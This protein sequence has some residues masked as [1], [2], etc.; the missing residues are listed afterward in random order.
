MIT[1]TD[2]LKATKGSC[3]GANPDTKIGELNFTGVS[4]DT[5]T[6]R[7]G[8]LFIALQGD[9]FDGHAYV[10]QAAAKGAAAAVVSRPVETPSG[11][12]Q[13]LVPDTLKA[14]Q[15]IASFYRM[16]FPHLKVVAIT[17]SNGKTSTKDMIAAVLATRY[18]VSKTRG[19]FNNEIGLP[20]TLLEIT[21]TTEIAVTEMGMRGL[22]QIKAMCAFAKPDVAVI[23]N[24]GSTHVGEL[25]SLA[26]IAK[27]KS[28]ILEDLP[29]DGFAVLNGDLPRVRAM[30]S[31]LHVPVSWFGL[32]PEDDVRAEAVEITATGSTFLCKAGTEEATIFLPLIGEHNVMNALAA[33]AVGRYFGVKLNDM[34]NALAAVR[35][36]DSRQEVLHFGSYTVIDDAYNA[37]PA[38]MEAAFAML[39]KL[40]QGAAAPCRTIAVVADMLELGHTS[41][42]AHASVGQMAAAAAT[43][44]LL[45]YGPETA[46]TVAAAKAAG[47]DARYFANKE[48]AAAALRTLLQPGDIVLL[49]GS[50]SMQVGV[51][52]ALVFKT[53]QSP[54][55]KENKVSAIHT[56]TLD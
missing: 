56:E 6:I 42:E 21:P 20:H 25:G 33:I 28:E 36:T 37:S 27:A 49:K 18:K 9:T 15:D 43:D 44:L 40:K 48:E 10:G 54:E 53:P 12:P 30:E 22:G 38:S 4:T 8:E 47:V 32:Q 55:N 45:G 19:N 46:E 52:V 13:I 41:R 50:H 51:L 14:Y 29:Q 24:V 16:S 39:A 7:P 3:P 35:I 23:T 17:G 31:K 11:L 1:L 26:N 2:V 34:K 5:R